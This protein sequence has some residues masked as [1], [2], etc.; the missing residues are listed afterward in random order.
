MWWVTLNLFDSIL[1]FSFRFD[2]IILND[3]KATDMVQV[4]QLGNSCKEWYKCPLCPSQ[5]IQERLFLKHMAQMHHTKI[6]PKPKKS[7]NPRNARK[8]EFKCNVCGKKYLSQTVLKKH[9]TEHGKYGTLTH[10]CSCCRKWFATSEDVDKHGKLHHK[11]KLFC[12]PCNRWFNEQDNYT[13]HIRY[14]HSFKN[15]ASTSP[16]KRYIYV[17]SKCGRECSSRMALSDHERASCGNDPIYK[18]LECNKCFHSAGSLKTHQTVHTGDLPHLCKY[19]GKAFRTQGQVKV[20]ER[21][22]NGEKPFKCE[23]KYPLFY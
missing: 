1:G 4:V 17:C 9:I 3:V 7:R 16:A 18:C 14:S 19:C 23:V 5:Y 10:K 2:N 6:Q 11:D 12:Q 22:H 21:K 8:S 20:H 13:A 15:N